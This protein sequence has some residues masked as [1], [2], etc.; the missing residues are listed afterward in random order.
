[1]EFQIDI[2]KSKYTLIMTNAHTGNFIA[3]NVKD[4][5]E[6]AIKVKE[7]LTYME[8]QHQLTLRILSMYNEF[9]TNELKKYMGARLKKSEMNN[10]SQSQ[11]NARAERSN[12]K[13]VGI[14][15]P[16]IKQR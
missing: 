12:L 10:T 8:V 2:V 11:E 6:T 16:I 15:I 7:M 1:M 5:Q 4:I 14:T 3:L 13:S 9:N